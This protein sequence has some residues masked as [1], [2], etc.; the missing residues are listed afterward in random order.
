MKIT[1]VTPWL[2]RGPAGAGAGRGGPPESGG[3]PPAAREYVFVQVETDEGMTGWGEVTG[4]RGRSPIGPSAP[5][6]ARW[7]RS[8]RAT[9]PRRSRPSG[10]RS[11]GP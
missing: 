8:W 6:C 10:T 1:R 9:T 7:G 4:L 3:A 11:S 5:C 2:V